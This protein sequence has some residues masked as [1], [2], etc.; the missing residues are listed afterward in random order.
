[1]K[2]SF[3]GFPKDLF[4]FLRELS[5]NNHRA[6]F[7][8][9]KARYRASAV[10]PVSEFIAAM[11]PR[12]A[13]ISDWF[14]AD[15]RPNGGSMFRIHRDSRFSEDKRPYKQ[16]VGCQFRHMAGKDAH[17][18]SFYVH[19]APD[20]VF[21]GAG[22]WT[23]PNPVLDKIRTA[24]VQN[25]GAWAKAARSTK[26][27]ERFD[28][29]G[30]RLARPPRG[31][32]PDHPYIEDIKRKSFFARQSFAPSLALKLGFIDEVGRA[33]IV[34]S[35]FM[36]FITGAVGLPYRRGREGQLTG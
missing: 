17:A 11:A 32:D 34:L 27:A 22:V 10:E 36:A 12:L 3:K 2:P 5:R 23:P 1:M 9:N 7:S 6:W 14:V 25:P 35:P 28:F 8:D 15:P 4:G 26:F 13:E 18:P 30:D 19:L 21:V 33:F 29:E 16:N 24:I 20:N 31:Y